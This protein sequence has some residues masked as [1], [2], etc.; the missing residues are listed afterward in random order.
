MNS[1]RK[2]KAGELE[3]A[4]LLRRYGF[5]CKRTPNSGGLDFKGDLWGMRD[6]HWEIKRVERLDLPKAWRQACADGGVSQIA[7]VAH[8]RSRDEWLVTLRADDYV[9]L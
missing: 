5:D 8:R 7:V 6:H 3:F 1:Q 9:A 4:H 2:G